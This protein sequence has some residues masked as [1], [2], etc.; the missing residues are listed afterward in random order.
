MVAC[1]LA[2]SN[3]IGSVG[4]VSCL[5]GAYGSCKDCVRLQEAA[6]QEVNNEQ[7][8]LITIL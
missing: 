2:C 8:G 5:G 1:A 4:C 3:A 6:V 7:G